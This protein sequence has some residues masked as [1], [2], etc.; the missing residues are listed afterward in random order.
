MSTDGN[1][2]AVFARF[3]S[4]SNAIK[5]SVE[6]DGGSFMFSE[7]LGFLGTCPSN[8]GTGL[9]GSVMIVLPELNKDVHLLEEICA[10][11]DLQPR[12]SAGEHS[13][14]VGAKWDISNKQRIG[15]TEVQL[16]QKMVDGVT[17]LIALEERLA[18]G[19]ELVKGED[20]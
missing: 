14:A 3:C 20:Y 16:V 8:L 10:S 15:F 13:A 17:K 9:R 18:A 7:S 6:S 2:K 5:E 12:G 11:F 1:V 4:I 19:Q